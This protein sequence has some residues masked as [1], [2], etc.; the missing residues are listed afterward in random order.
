LRI[1]LYSAVLVALIEFG[2]AK[3]GAYLG[4]AD[5]FLSG[6]VVCNS[7]P[8]NGGSG[9]CTV[10]SVWSG[11][12][13]IQSNIDDAT[14]FQTWSHV[15]MQGSD[16]AGRANA[17]SKTLFQFR[18]ASTTLGYQ[19]TVTVARYRMDSPPVAGS[20]CAAGYDVFVQSAAHTISS[21]TPVGDTRIESRLLPIINF[22]TETQINH[23][24]GYRESITLSGMPGDSSTKNGCFLIEWR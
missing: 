13:W 18:E 5:E 9:G 8:Q 11:R 4:W 1:Y 24:V 23:T 16:A 15:G 17:K 20:A 7:N 3:A 22:S 10:R 19:A 6:F 12:Y 2:S 21:Y 14:M